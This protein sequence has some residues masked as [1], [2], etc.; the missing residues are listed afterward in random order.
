MSYS[1][2]NIELS[3]SKVRVVN[4]PTYAAQ[5]P[6]NA[7]AAIAWL[8]PKYLNMITANGFMLYRDIQV[9]RAMHPVAPPCP[10]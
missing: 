2:V 4:V 8:N 5:R 6:I 9:T 7:V 1:S 3:L 10:F